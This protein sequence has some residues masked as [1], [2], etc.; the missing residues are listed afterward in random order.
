MVTHWVTLT[1]LLLLVG[2]EC[3]PRAQRRFGFDEPAFSAASYDSLGIQPSRT[4]NIYERF[5]G[6]MRS[7]VNPFRKVGRGNEQQ[8]WWQ[9]PQSPFSEGAA[10]N[11]GVVSGGRPGGQTVVGCSGDGCSSPLF[12]GPA[13]AAS[14]SSSSS[15]GGGSCC[16]HYW[17]KP[18]HPCSTHQG[19]DCPRGFNC[20]NYR[21]CSNGVISHGTNSGYASQ[22]PSLDE[23]NFDSLLR[24]SVGVTNVCFCDVVDELRPTLRVVRNASLLWGAKAAAASGPAADVLSSVTFGSVELLC[25]ETRRRADLLPSR[26][27]VPDRKTGFYHSVASARLH[28]ATT[29]LHHPGTLQAAAANFSKCLSNSSTHL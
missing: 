26:A 12:S 8:Y 11:Q 4:G 24:V 21:S 9:G 22:K 7:I 6:E 16:N 25:P 13:V 1:C 15:S 5:V 10:Q 19:N 27:R 2:V 23:V 18:G 20:V 3:K 28:S 29:C 14:S 17:Q